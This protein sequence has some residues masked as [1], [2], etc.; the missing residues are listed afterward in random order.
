M[1]NCGKKHRLL[2]EQQSLFWEMLTERK[3]RLAQGG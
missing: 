1:E 2:V 3:N